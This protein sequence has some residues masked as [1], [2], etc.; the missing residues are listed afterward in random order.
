MIYARITRSNTERIS[1]V[2]RAE[3]AK[4][5]PLGLR[6]FGSPKLNYMITLRA[7]VVKVT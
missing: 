5:T 3:S 1:S 7:R 2:R 6:E 4:Y